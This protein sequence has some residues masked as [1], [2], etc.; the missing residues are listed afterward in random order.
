MSFEETPTRCNRLTLRMLLLLEVLL[1]ISQTFAQSTTTLPV[2]QVAQTGSNDSQTNALY[3][4]LRIP[5]AKAAQ[6][7]GMISF[8]DPIV[9]LA[10]PSKP[11]TDAGV[12]KRLFAS[13]KNE[14]PGAVRFGSKPLISRRW[15][16]GRCSIPG[17]R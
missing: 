10:I 12:L 4:S 2:Y 7:N 3:A 17:R 9:Y 8:V 15:V 1:G 11:V 16:S 14:G 6:K 13:T 5:A